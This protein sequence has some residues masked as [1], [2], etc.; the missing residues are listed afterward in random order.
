MTGSAC[1]FSKLVRRATS[2]GMARK[3]LFVCPRGM[4]YIDRPFEV[5]KSAEV[6]G[7][8]ERMA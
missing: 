1:N 5:S 2:G 4:E 8:R 6:A 3:D 7:N